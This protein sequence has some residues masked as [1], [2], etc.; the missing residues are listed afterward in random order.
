MKC[1]HLVKWL[2]FSC[3]A[4]DE[5]Y[6]PSPFQVGEYCKN[7]N[8]KKCPFLLKMDLYGDYCRSYQMNE[9]RQGE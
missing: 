2:L 4:G 7:R 8:Y 6:F 3:K 9:M 1:P 5:V